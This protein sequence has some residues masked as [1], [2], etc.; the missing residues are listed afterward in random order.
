MSVEHSARLICPYFFGGKELSCGVGLALSSARSVI[1][2]SFSIL[3]SAVNFPCR[4]ICLL[5]KSSEFSSSDLVNK[6]ESIRKEEGAILK[7]MIGCSD[8]K[9]FNRYCQKLRDIDLRILKIAES[10]AKKNLRESDVCNL[11]PYLTGRVTNVS[12][13]SNIS[14]LE[15]EKFVDRVCANH[16][17][18]VNE[19]RDRIKI[20]L[21]KGELKCLGIGPNNFIKTIYPLGSETHNRG[22]IPLLI[23]FDNHRKIVY[24]PRST[25][26]ERL[27]CD[28]TDSVLKVAGFGTYK[29]IC[30]SDRNGS[31]GYCEFLENKKEEN[32][33]SDP[34]KFFEYFQRLVLLDEIA[35]RL[36]ISDLHYE[37]IL[38]RNCEPT[39]IDAEVFATS[40][41]TMIFDPNYGTA[42]RVDET[43]VNRIWFDP[44]MGIEPF[45]NYFKILENLGIK[46]ATEFSRG[47]SRE[48]CQK[49]EE[50]CK[51]L[52]REKA[53]IVPIRTSQLLDQ[54]YKCHIGYK[55]QMISEF[56]VA[57]EDSL[58]RKGFVFDETVLSQIREA[59]QED[60]SNFDVPIFYYDPTA[61]T[62]IYHNI[63]IAR[64]LE[65]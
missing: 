8:K 26:P 6:I 32:T 52:K 33:F 48:V 1:A 11:I 55:E 65:C 41:P 47:L 60:A 7:G 29:V 54:V 27:L 17:E 40:D 9:L 46:D 45:C 53:R 35:L 24:K 20:D 21:Q 43:G 13:F 56:V 12:S 5:K 4:V 16:L 10:F 49:I 44:S 39:V 23:E 25:E 42:W 19:A 50:A 63:V 2:S 51:K 31:Y 36:G 61:Q 58:K 34:D 30:K 18:F 14:A 38:V 64:A 22:R 3:C 15:K 37:N 57:L 62:V 28:T 59:F